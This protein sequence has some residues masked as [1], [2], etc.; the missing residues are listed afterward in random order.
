M[1]I[2]VA[3]RWWLKRMI[4]L[5]EEEVRREAA[6]VIQARARGSILRGAP[7]AT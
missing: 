2:Q 3:F 5:E 1:T 6:R 4:R 7:A